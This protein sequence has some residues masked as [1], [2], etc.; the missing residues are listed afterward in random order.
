M[1][2]DHYYGGEQALLPVSAGLIK[3][4]HSADWITFL[5]GG[6][7][8]ECTALEAVP[9]SLGW[10]GQLSPRSLPSLESFWDILVPK[11]ASIQTQCYQLAE[12]RD[13]L[14]GLWYDG[15]A[16]GRHQA[17]KQLPR[18]MQF[19]TKMAPK[20][21]TSDS[22]WNHTGFTA[23]WGKEGETFPYCRIETVVVSKWIRGVN[24]FLLQG[25]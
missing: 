18:Q 3:A 24:F 2:R 11:K 20:D 23:L 17:K 19:D 25:N 12:D 10:S 22:F 8:R 15:N 9:P 16:R 13:S 7:R 5:C 1:H 21:D 6:S 4:H 14:C